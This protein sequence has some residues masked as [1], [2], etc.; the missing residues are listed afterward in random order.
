MNLRFCIVIIFV[1]L[2]GCSTRQAPAPVIDVQAQVPLSKKLKNKIKSTEYLVKKGETLYSIAW[3]ADI[4]VRSIALLNNISA[5]YK[6]FP[7]QKIFLAKK[8]AKASKN[9]S[10]SKTLQKS[11]Q[12]VVKKPVASN[13]KQEYG[14]IVRGQKTNEKPANDQSQFSQKVKQWKWPAIK[15]THTPH[16]L[17]QETA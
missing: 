8:S 17:N 15:T 12:R 9:E 16:S 1:F 13:K 11:Q 2:V 3:R 5:P 6:I 14:E 4:D 7:G 10:S